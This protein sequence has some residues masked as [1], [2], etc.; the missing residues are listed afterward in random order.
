MSP[1]PTPAPPGAPATAVDHLALTPET[2]ASLQ[3]LIVDD[4]RTLRESCVSMLKHDG[5]NVRACARGDE[6][7][8][9]LKRLRFDIVLLDLYMSQVPGIELLQA[10]L[11]AHPETIVIVMTGNPPIP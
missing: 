4:E 3:I 10:C 11:E 9:T 8:D 2:K 6:A 5:Y 7:L 1:Q